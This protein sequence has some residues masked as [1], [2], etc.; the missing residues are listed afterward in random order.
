MQRPQCEW[1]RWPFLRKVSGWLFT[2]KYNEPRLRLWTSIVF[3]EESKLWSFDTLPKN[4]E[5]GILLLLVSHYI[6]LNS[7]LIEL[8]YFCGNDEVDEIR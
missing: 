4:L 1:K 8:T 7:S 5:L 3:S 2:S 6:P